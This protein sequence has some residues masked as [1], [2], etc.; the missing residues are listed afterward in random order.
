MVQYVK[1]S[2]E[3][4]KNHVTW[5]TLADSQ[6]EMVVVVVFSI[7]F[8]LV[9]WGMDSFFEWIIAEYFKFMQ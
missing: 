5:P 3:E 7:L 9:I 2:Y 1:E 8:S 6:R 4:L